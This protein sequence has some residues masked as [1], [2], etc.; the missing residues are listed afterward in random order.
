MREHLFKGFHPDANGTIE[1]TLNGE[2]IKGEWVIGDGIHYPKSINYKGTCWIDGMQEKAND[3][4]QVLSETVCEYT[5]LTDTNGNKIFNHAIVAFHYGHN[6]DICEVCF[7]SGAFGLGKSYP[8][9]FDY[10]ELETSVANATENDS[11][12]VGND[13]FISLWEIA[14]NYNEY[15]G[16]NLH[17]IEIIGNIFENSELLK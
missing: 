2:K 15:A 17:L 8:K 5:G 16:E 9:K 4:V 14:W 7:E 6:K 10:D 1:I 3:W 13:N 11:Y 12:F